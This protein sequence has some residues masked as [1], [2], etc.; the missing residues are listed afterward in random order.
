MTKCRYA[1]EAIRILEE[2]RN[3]YDLV[4]VDVY[5]TEMNGFELLKLI[6]IE[7]NLPVISKYIK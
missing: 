5:L 6:G 3:H 1:K 7:T 4:I 2:D